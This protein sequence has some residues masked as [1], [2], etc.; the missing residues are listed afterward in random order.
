[1]VV[2]QVAWL[3]AFLVA[4]P[5]LYAACG[6]RSSTDYDWTSSPGAPGTGI[7]TGTGGSRTGSGGG[8]GTTGTGGS[9]GGSGGSGGSGGTGG[10]GDSGGPDIRMPCGTVMNGCSA[11]SQ[12]NAV[13]DL[14][15]NRCVQCLTDP[16]CAGQ[17][18]NKT[19]DTRASGNNRLPA[20]RCVQCLDN[21]HCPPGATCSTSNNTCSTACGTRT[22]STN[23]TGNTVCDAPNDRCVQC[24]A[25]GDCASQA[26]NKTCDLRTNMQGLPTGRCIGCLDNSNCAAGSMCID[27]TCIAGCSTDNDC[28]ADGGGRTPRCNPTTKVCAQ[29]GSD[30]HCTSNNAPACGPAGTCVRCSSDAHCA[31]TMNQPFCSLT[32]TCVQCFSDD[33][34][35]PPMTCNTRG[36]CSGGG[37]GG[38]R[39]GGGSGGDDGGGTPPIPDS[40]GGTPPTPDSGGGTPPTSD[41]GGGGRGG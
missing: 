7:L 26:T 24:L 31:S 2:K 14:A 11:N 17:T 8:I 33:Q 32:N 36:S 5:T 21:T 19:C 12:G 28:S 6:G 4:T 22:C 20:D 37:G 39:D 18:T 29:C 40:G 30:A 13:C 1:M 34:C 38:G 41:S 35:V 9:T 10:I 3:A 15:N 27:N 23:P 25:D 16:D